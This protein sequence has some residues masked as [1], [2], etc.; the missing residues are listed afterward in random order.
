MATTELSYAFREVGSYPCFVASFVSTVS[1]EQQGSKERN[2]H[3]KPDERCDSEVPIPILRFIDSEFPIR[4][5]C[6]SRKTQFCKNL[7]L[8]SLSS[9]ILFVSILVLLCN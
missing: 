6:K 4:K 8:V 3:G 2:C 7:A 9:L 1:S 5:F